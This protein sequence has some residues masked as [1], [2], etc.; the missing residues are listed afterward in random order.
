MRSYTITGM[1]PTVGTLLLSVLCE[2]PYLS[3]RENCSRTEDTSSANH[4]NPGWSTVF[5]HDKWTRG[6]SNCLWSGL[7]VVDEPPI[8]CCSAP[9]R[10]S[11]LHHNHTAHCHWWRHSY[12]PTHS[13]T[14]SVEHAL[15][16]DKSKK[17]VSVMFSY[18]NA[19][20][21]KL[22]KIIHKNVG[23]I[24]K[25]GDLSTDVHWRHAT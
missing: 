25:H 10:R 13:H 15:L 14:F 4:G 20:L 8:S 6:C 18:M 5:C 21:L 9:V 3:F 2:L 22:H 1:Q 11:P 7:L 24:D 12:H 16:I 19:Y 17:N 23:L